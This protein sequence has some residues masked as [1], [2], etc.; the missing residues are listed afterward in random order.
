M[1]WF[2]LLPGV[3]EHDVCPLI[4]LVIRWPWEKDWY[5]LVRNSLILVRLSGRLVFSAS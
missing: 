3:L 4:L 2:K 1:L 5:L